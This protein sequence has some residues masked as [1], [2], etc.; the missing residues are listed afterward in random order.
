[1]GHEKIYP[2]WNLDLS[3]EIPERSQFRPLPPIGV[4]SPQVESLTGYVARLAEAHV[5]SVGDMIGREPLS[6]TCTGIPHRTVRFEK[7]RPTGHVFHAGF[8]Y[9]N[10]ISSTARS[11]AKAFERVTSVQGFDLLTL[12]PLHRM[13]SDMSLLKRYRAW[14]PQCY[15]EDR[16]KGFPYE[17]LL[18]SLRSVTACL[19]HGVALEERCPFCSRTLPALSVYSQPGYC[20]ACGEWLGMQES[21]GDADV[22]SYALYVAT[23]VGDLLAG[24]SSKAR[25]SG[26]RFRRNLRVCI[27]RVA[28]G[29]VVAFAELTHTSKTTLR[30]WLIGETLPRLDVLLR[31]AYDLGIS[32]RDLLMS[33]GLH[34]ADWTGIRSRLSLATRNA[35]CYRS[36]ESLLCL[37]MAALR[38][39]ACPSVPELAKGL[40]YK[41][42]ERLR[43]V[44]PDL[45]RRLTRRHRACRRTHWWRQPG[46]K[47]IAELDR[48]RALLEQSLKQ[49]PPTSVQRIARQLGYA[50]GNGGVIHRSFPDLC[51]SMAKKRKEWKELRTKEV[52][53]AVT[54][55]ILEEAPPT[56]HEMSQRLGFQTS[57]TLRSWVPDLADRLLQARAE[58][59]AAEKNRL[60]AL[61]IRVLQENPVPSLNSVAQRLQRSTAFLIERH[62]DLCRVIAAC[63]L[64]RRK[65]RRSVAAADSMLPCTRACSP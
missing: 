37:M 60:R 3:V 8:S 65:R 15:E 52:R 10:G 16:R 11:W 13:L 57:T 25:L 26:A 59:A 23:A 38:D 61:L 14:C 5:L 2:V 56:L 45:C 36:S 53:R 64:Q 34:D 49:N 51:Q 7:T 29:N 48:I 50:G 31:F 21:R 12:L 63:H 19:I 54:A 30:G 28:S 62:P 22:D 24:L 17:R 40:G 32:V 42:P 1:V 4:G 6:R 47:R 35:K 55:A 46:A 18:W 44:S 41:R 9:V 39:D 20:S 27:Q 43:Q 33:R 58:H